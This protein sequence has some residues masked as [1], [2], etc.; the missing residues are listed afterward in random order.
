MKE[1]RKAESKQKK[2]EI[3][4][5]YHKMDNKLHQ[6][7]ISEYDEKYKIDLVLIRDEVW[8]RIPKEKQSGIKHPRDLDLVY[9]FPTNVLGIERIINHF[10][11]LIRLLP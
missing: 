10:E 4:E 2:T 3:R 5:K 9:Q 6:R 7:L 11:A 8:S 1:A